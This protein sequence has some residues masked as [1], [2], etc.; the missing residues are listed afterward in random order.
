MLIA[1]AA[2]ATEWE[3]IGIILLK[4]LAIAFL[5]LLN[6]FFG[7]SEF[8]IVKVRGS[9]LDAMIGRYG[10]RDVRPSRRH[11]PRRDERDKKKGRPVSRPFCE[12]VSRRIW[13]LAAV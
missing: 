6:G 1:A 9:R 5:V 7:A 8:A 3:P 10:G 11:E 13:I 4:L 2:P 12:F